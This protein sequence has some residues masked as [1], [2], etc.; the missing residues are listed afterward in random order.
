MSNIFSQGSKDIETPLQAVG[1][2]VARLFARIN[3]NS[4][5]NVAKTRWQLKRYAMTC[6]DVKRTLRMDETHSPSPTKTA[7]QH[8]RPEE[9]IAPAYP[10]G[11][12]AAGPPESSMS[13]RHIHTIPR[14]P[15][16]NSYPSD[17]AGP[18]NHNPPTRGFVADTQQAAFN[19]KN[20]SVTHLGP[21]GARDD[22]CRIYGNICGAQ[23]SGDKKLI[24][25]ARDSLRVVSESEI[26]KRVGVRNGCGEPDSCMAKLLFCL[27]L[28]PWG[29][30]R[31]EKWDGV[32]FLEVARD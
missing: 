32:E 17:I 13:Q 9:D 20:T 5:A 2:M 1:R 19:I 26:L 27:A 6:L 30:A 24:K 7:S 21:P 8:R 11:Y 4:E 12:G 14:S 23:L 18:H 22:R 3:V 31:D 16:S 25:Q 29:L 28:D 10:W 15:N